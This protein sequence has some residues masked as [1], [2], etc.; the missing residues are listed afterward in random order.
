MFG[1]VPM[2]RATV[3]QSMSRSLPATGDSPSSTRTNV[4][5]ETPSTPPDAALMTWP[6]NT[7]T[8][9]AC[10]ASASAAGPTGAAATSTMAATSSP[11]SSAVSARSNASAPEPRISSFRPA[12][13]S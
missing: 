13:A 1:T 5:R 7:G 3:S 6:V 11:R 12:K 10:T 4:A 8:P 9:C 2:A